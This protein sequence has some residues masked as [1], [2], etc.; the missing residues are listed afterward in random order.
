MA[1][2][3]KQYRPATILL[4]WMLI[5][6]NFVLPVGFLV[7]CHILLAFL[8]SLICSAISAGPH[9]SVFWFWSCFVSCY[10]DIFNESP[11]LQF[12][13]FNGFH[14]YSW[15]DGFLKFISEDVPISMFICKINF[16]FLFK[17]F[18]WTNITENKL[19]ET[20]WH[21]GH[22]NVTRTVLV[23]GMRMQS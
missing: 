18:S 22:W 11:N 1:G 13:F 4:T 2:L 16:P 17:G 12:Q 23:L 3:S 15:V 19:V 5:L 14:T 9:W 7:V 6:L 20:S 10:S 21:R 8:L